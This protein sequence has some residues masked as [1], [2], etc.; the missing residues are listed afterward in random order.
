MLA[1]AAILGPRSQG[2]LCRTP[3]RK[4]G[5]DSVDTTMLGV[6]EHLLNEVRSY[7]YP[8]LYCIV[9]IYIFMY[10]HKYIV[11]FCL[12]WIRRFKGMTF[13]P[14]IILFTFRANHRL[15]EVD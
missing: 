1:K 8:L 9:Y 2:D 11:D 7:V 4:F 12:S 6:C 14:D 10:V 5:V 3:G 13:R 15:Y